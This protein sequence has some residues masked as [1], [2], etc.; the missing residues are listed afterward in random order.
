[1]PLVNRRKKACD[2]ESCGE[3]AT[4][5]SKDKDFCW[6]HYSEATRTQ[7]LSKKIILLIGVIGT[8]IGV[9]TGLYF[10]VKDIFQI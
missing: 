6:K 7:R 8:I 5:S 1:M 10:F 2:K 3:P 4:H 9:P